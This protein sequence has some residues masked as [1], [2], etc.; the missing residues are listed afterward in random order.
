MNERL[1]QLDSESV[2]NLVKENKMLF[3]LSVIFLVAVY[4]RFIPAGDMEYLQA[5]DSYLIY[6]FS[7]HIALDWSLP[8]LDF[9]RYFPYAFPTYAENIGSFYIPAIL[10]WLG[11]FL[12]LDYI[13]WAQ[14]FPPLMGGLAVITIYFIGKEAFDPLTGVSAAFFLAT[15]AGVMHRTGAGFFQKDPTSAA[16]MLISIYFFMRAW[17]RNDWYSGI[18][19]GTALGLATISWGGSSMLWLL[20][21]L[22]IGVMLWINEDIDNLVTAYTPTILIGAFLAASLNHD[23]FW[24]TD[25]DFLANLAMLLFLW[26]R[27][28]IEELNLVKESSLSYYVPTVSVFGLI[29]AVLSPLYSQELANMVMRLLRRVTRQHSDTDIIAGTVAENTPV[30]LAELSSQLGSVGVGQAHMFISDPYSFLLSP[31]TAIGSLIGNFNGPWP[32]AFIGVAFLS[33]GLVVL[34]MRKLELLEDGLDDKLFYQILVVVLILWTASFSF[35]FDDPTPF[36]TMIAVGPALVGLGA[37]L[38]ILYG[39]D[40][41]GERKIEVEWYHIILVLWAISTI[42]AASAQSRLVF[43][44]AYPTAFMAGYMFAKV[45]KRLRTLEEES[46]R[47]LSIGSGILFIDIVLIIALLLSG[48]G[49]ILAVVAVGVL[50]GLGYVIINDLN[51]DFSLETQ[52]WSSVF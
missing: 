24:L 26:S 13:T 1:K 51:R 22:T 16:F 49:I 2:K 43:L 3:L 21:A 25:L 39:L 31:F 9:M 41:F 23:R 32:L 4:I 44:A 27:Y 40:E 7:Q 10:Y 20:Y 5:L 30:T 29:A 50:N 14:L 37:A 42:L 18:G 36:A 33:A 17:K 52:R 8:A 47:Y 28:L 11:P 6:R 34:L 38:I 35:V 46:V 12:F 15:I 45:I 19:A 48:I